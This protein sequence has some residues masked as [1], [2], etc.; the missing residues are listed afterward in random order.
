MTVHAALAFSP[1]FKRG[2]ISRG[3]AYG[4]KISASSLAE[5]DVIHYKVVVGHFTEADGARFMASVSAEASDGGWTASFGTCSCPASANC[6][7]SVALALEWA[8]GLGAAQVSPDGVGEIASESVQVP[9]DAVAAAEAEPGSAVQHSP[10]HA[11]HDQPKQARIRRRAPDA[12]QDQPSAPRPVPSYILSLGDV[13]DGGCG[14]RAIYRSPDR[15]SP[16]CTALDIEAFCRLPPGPGDDGI[17]D[18]MRPGIE[19]SGRRA[20]LDDAPGDAGVVRD[21]V[22][23]GRCRWMGSDR[24]VTG[25]MLSWSQ[26]RHAD[27]SWGLAE[28]GTQTS[29]VACSPRL[30]DV[31]TAGGEHFYVDAANARIGHLADGLTAAAA[32]LMMQQHALA[33]REVPAF[34]RMMD[35]LETGAPRP[36]CLADFRTVRDPVPVLRAVRPDGGDP[37]FGKPRFELQFSYAGTLFTAGT[38]TG[39]IFVQGVDGPLRII[40]NPARERALGE[41]MRVACSGRSYVEFGHRAARLRSEGWIIDAE[42]YA[43]PRFVEA[44]KWDADFFEERQ[45]AGIPWFSFA[46]SATIE[47]TDIDMSDVLRSMLRQQAPGDA[48]HDGMLYIPLEDGRILP[49]AAGRIRPLLAAIG[50]LNGGRDGESSCRLDVAAELAAAALAVGARMSGAPGILGLATAFASGEFAPVPCP[51]SFSGELRNYQEDGAS[52]LSLL[53]AHGL[54]GLLA[55]DMGLGKTPTT[56]FHLCAEHAAGRL[57]DQALVVAPLSVR[58]VWIAAARQF[59]PGL[60]LHVW[61]SDGKGSL[62]PIPQGTSIV[63]TTYGMLERHAS[64]IAMRR[65]SIAVLDE[66]Q[67]IKNPGS[68]VS[69][70]AARLLA[71]QRIALSG[72]PV[73]NRLMDLWSIFR[74]LEPSLLG[75]REKFRSTYAYPIEQGGD[76]EAGKQLSRLV[77]PFIMRRTKDEVAGDLPPKVDNTEFIQLGP[78]QARLY[79][80]VRAATEHSVQAALR[81]QGRD[82]G[83]IVILT[84]LLRLRQA[85]LDARLVPGSHVDKAGTS[86]KLV[87]LVEMV[88]EAKSEGRKVLVF[89]QFAQM[90][91][92]IAAELAAAGVSYSTLTGKTRNRGTLVEDFQAGTKDVFLISLKAGGSGITLTGADVVVHF[93]PW[94]N[95]AV[96]NQATDRAHRIGQTRTVFVHRL[97]AVGTIEE[98]ILELQEKKKAVAQAVFSEDHAALSL[99]TEDEIRGLFSISPAHH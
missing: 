19:A 47:G 11:G 98:G 24:K 84:A 9:E 91:D 14:L 17:L 93:D 73:E 86:A 67:N 41:T 85:C 38:P 87:R 3:R 64:R 6:I 46:I 77:K 29:C 94:W 27:L 60:S 39:E 65:W 15:D 95:P 22:V 59:A 74:F 72:T 8:R 1:D 32:S 69:L 12:V 40:R 53:S 34:L 57:A 13:P 66:A 25:R 90:L 7:H 52:W 61:E 75:P 71:R 49:V 50:M 68:K 4:R 18:R 48:A 82:K 16:F 26:P 35:R 78:E 55:F 42:G 62:A 23:T 54:G 5:A 44:D 96:E 97:I 76:E 36:T 20:L 2:V 10:V 83:R 56:L 70:A 37:L 99:L 89:S 30:D 58:S 63:V 21:A 31:F 43:E 45:P 33:L 81:L 80:A 79:E 88:L 28:D 92:L 51:A